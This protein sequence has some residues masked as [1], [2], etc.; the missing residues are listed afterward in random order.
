[1]R[2]RKCKTLLSFYDVDSN[3]WKNDVEEF[4]SIC[5]RCKTETK[6]VSYLFE[7]GHITIPFL[8]MLVEDSDTEVREKYANYMP[9]EQREMLLK[10]LQ[11]CEI[12]SSKMEQIRLSNLSHSLLFDR[13]TYEFFM[14]RAKSINQEVECKINGVGLK[15]FS[16]Q[17]NTF[18]LSKKDLFF[19]LEQNNTKLW[20]YF[21]ERD[22]CSV[23]MA[24]LKKSLN[25]VVLE[26]IWLKS[27]ERIMKE[28]QFIRELSIGNVRDLFASSKK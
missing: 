14:S 6:F 8:E 17:G 11:Q 20:C 26:K 13:E 15:S 22:S 9:K 21:L 25:K 24:S 27:S 28:K 1:M 12:C 2:C 18:L 19:E 5:P 3:A 16:F 7:L 10:H 4:V 23:G